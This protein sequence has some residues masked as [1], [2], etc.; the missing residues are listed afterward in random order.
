MSTGATSWHESPARDATAARASLAH[1]PAPWWQVYVVVYT[2]VALLE[3]RTAFTSRVVHSVWR[4]AAGDMPSSF[5]R[6]VFAA[7]APG[8]RLAMAMM[9]R[10]CAPYAA[11]R[12]YSI[13]DLRR[14]AT[15]ANVVLVDQSGAAVGWLRNVPTAW[16]A[17]DVLA[18]AGVAD[19]ATGCVAHGLALQPGVPLAAHAWVTGFRPGR[20]D[21]CVVLPKVAPKAPRDND[22]DDAA[23][24][25]D[26]AASTPLLP[27]D[28]AVTAAGGGG[29]S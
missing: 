20:G 27:V 14:S 21:L 29:A 12:V 15:I 24:S 3:P 16:T 1:L 8:A 6:R 7:L 5:W 19:T 22:E 10:A 2:V 11:A 9:E 18:A 4:E 17:A 26:A 25:T 28:V 23:L 13:T